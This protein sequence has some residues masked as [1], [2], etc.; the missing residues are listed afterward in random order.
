MEEIRNSLSEMAFDTEI[1]RYKEIIR[2]T[3]KQKKKQDWYIKRHARL[4][5]SFHTVAI[6]SILEAGSSYSWYITRYNSWAAV[7][8]QW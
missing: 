5:A 2:K 1:N 3:A 7:P 6:S 4:P 8:Y